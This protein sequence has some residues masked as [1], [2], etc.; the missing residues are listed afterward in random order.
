MFILQDGG[1]GER[2]LIEVEK[3]IEKWQEP[4]PVKQV[5]ALPAPIDP[6]AKYVLLFN[7][8]NRSKL[9]VRNISSL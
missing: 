5:K 2:M 9:S 6:P 4:P 7:H 8:G 3:K 1:M